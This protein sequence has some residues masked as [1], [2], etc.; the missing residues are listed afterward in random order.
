[1]RCISRSQQLSRNMKKLEEELGVALFE[2][3]KNRLALNENGEYVLRI[4]RELLSSADGLPAR[5]RNSTAGTALLPSGPLRACPR[6][7]C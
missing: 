3:R 6:A 7:G 2:R 4:A 5:V 1:M